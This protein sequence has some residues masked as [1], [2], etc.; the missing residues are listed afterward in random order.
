MKSESIKAR[1]IVDRYD[2][3]GKPFFYTTEF[4]ELQRLG[5]PHD[6]NWHTTNI[7]IGSILT[8]D[9]RK[10]EVKDMMACILDESQQVDR[11]IGV[12]MYGYGEQ[13]HP[14]NFEVRWYVLPYSG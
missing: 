14:F 1:F 4:S 10:Y 13:E 11:N 2:H 12:N 6:A 8:I 5:L 3:Q 9:G 7:M